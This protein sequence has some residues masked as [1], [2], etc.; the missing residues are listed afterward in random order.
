MAVSTARFQLREQEYSKIQVYLSL[1]KLC[2]NNFVLK[3]VRS[4]ESTT[5]ALFG[6]MLINSNYREFQVISNRRNKRKKL[7]LSIP[8]LCAVLLL[9]C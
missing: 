9:F 4:I 5:K 7:P 2:Q 3:T 1:L 8:K 6:E